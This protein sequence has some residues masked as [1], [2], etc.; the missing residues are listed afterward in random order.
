VPGA[1]PLTCRMGGTRIDTFVDKFSRNVSPGKH[2][3]V[4]RLPGLHHIVERSHRNST[5]GRGFYSSCRVP[6]PCRVLCD[7]AGGGDFPILGNERR[8][9]NGLAPVPPPRSLRCSY[10]LGPEAIPRSTLPSFRYLQL[11]CPHV[12][13]G[14]PG[15]WPIFACTIPTEGAPSLR[16]LQGWAAMLSTQ[17]LSVLHCPKTL[18]KQ[19]PFVSTI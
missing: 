16:F 8:N 7:R 18:R 3:L 10:A 19:F 4:G 17:L 12:P 11:L 1:A 13:I 2:F 15:G 5:S 6:R 14:H 9:L